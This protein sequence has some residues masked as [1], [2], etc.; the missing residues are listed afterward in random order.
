M[1]HCGSKVPVQNKIC[2]KPKFTF[3]THNFRRYDLWKSQL[4]YIPPRQRQGNPDKLWS[5]VLHKI[6]AKPFEWLTHTTLINKNEFINRQQHNII[7]EPINQKKV[8]P[9]KLF[10]ME[11]WKTTDQSWY[12]IAKKYEPGSAVVC[13]C[14]I[15]WW[16]C[17]WGAVE[18]L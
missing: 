9:R 14:D 10:T 2:G 18:F 13:C 3:T 6:R 5:N 4:S 15:G 16:W 8:K 17:E 11:R 12:I 1:T 7:G